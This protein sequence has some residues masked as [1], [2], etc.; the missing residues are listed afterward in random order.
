MFVV[1]GEG[2]LTPGAAHETKNTAWGLGLSTWSSWSTG[3]TSAST[4]V[5]LRA[6]CTDRRLTGSSLT[7]GGSRG[8]RTA[9]SGSGSPR[10]SSKPHAATTLRAVPSIA[11]FKTRK[12]R[13]LW[14]VRLRQPR[15]SLADALRSS[16]GRLRKQFM[17]RYGVEY[18][19]VDEPAPSDPAEVQGA[20]CANLR[21]T[22]EVL[23]RDEEL[24]DWLS[25]RLV[26]IAESVPENI[27]GFR[28]GDGASQ[29]VHRSPFLRLRAL[30]GQALEAAW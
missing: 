3:T 16:S 30:P 17:E 26:S 8:P 14:Q 23:R 28:L 24:V 21:V 1:E 13:G 2:G 11:W 25:D 20:G 6:S 9:L 19:G 29:G 22:M 18:H 5:R 15:Q 27:E 12:G 7:A 4:R 10:L